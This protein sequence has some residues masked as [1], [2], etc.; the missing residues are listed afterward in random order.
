VLLFVLI[1]V[2]GNRASERRERAAISA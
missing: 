2:L 1:V